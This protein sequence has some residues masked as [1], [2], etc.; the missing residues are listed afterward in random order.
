MANRIPVRKVADLSA[1]CRAVHPAES[2]RAAVRCRPSGGRP[3]LNGRRSGC[4]DRVA[5]LAEGLRDLAPPLE[6]DLLLLHLG[7][8]GRGLLAER[9]LLLP[10]CNVVLSA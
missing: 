1:D 8:G 4:R 7:L 6:V 10:L 2:V 3:W 5:E 9:H